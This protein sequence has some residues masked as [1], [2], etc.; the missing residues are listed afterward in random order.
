MRF[1]VLSGLILDVKKDDTETLMMLAEL[2][3]R[4][5][6]KGERIKEHDEQIKCFGVSEF[7]KFVNPHNSKAEDGYIDERLLEEIDEEIKSAKDAENHNR[8]KALEDIKAVATEIK[9][10]DDMQDF[11]DFYENIRGSSTDEA[12]LHCIKQ[13]I[14]E[15]R[16]G[17]AYYLDAN[18][19][20]YAYLIASKDKDDFL[21]RLD[22]VNECLTKL[23]EQEK[24]EFSK[25]AE[26][27]KANKGFREE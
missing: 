27:A 9:G 15:L 20:I 14:E 1:N 5:N 24:E 23:T 10:E 17:N 2:L 26:Q 11:Q 16:E 21:K 4:K 19:T 18:N 25:T 6:E 3:T 22:E 13:L 12:V 8:V 7:R